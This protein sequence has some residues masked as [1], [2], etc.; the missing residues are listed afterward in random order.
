[1]NR[2]KRLLETISSLIKG[3]FSGYIKINFSQGSL[4]RVEQSEELDETI[5]H[6]GER[7]GKNKNVGNNLFFDNVCDIRDS[8]DLKGSFGQTE[9]SNHDRRADNN[10][11]TG[12]EKRCGEDRRSG[13][14]RRSG[15]DRNGQI[16]DINLEKKIETNRITAKQK[17]KNTNH[18]DTEK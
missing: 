13:W 4:G 16:P 3:E 14:D 18:R 6:S 15:H 10:H 17:Q 2:V 5:I 7:K 9:R 1:M 11:Y 12:Y 8:T